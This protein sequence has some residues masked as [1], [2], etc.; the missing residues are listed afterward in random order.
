M[1]GFL[2]AITEVLL[3]IPRKVFGWLMDGLS[4]LINSVP[5]PQF[6]TD[7]AGNASAIPPEVM[8]FVEP[9]GI[10]TGAAIIVTAYTLRFLIRRL[11]VVG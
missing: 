4:A 3:Y 7:L 10:D 8:F 11:P 9:F 2:D 5:V 1:Q 6:M